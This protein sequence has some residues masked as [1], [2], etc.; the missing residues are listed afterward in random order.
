MKALTKSVPLTCES[1][2]LMFRVVNIKCK[3]FTNNEYTMSTI[4]C[5]LILE[6]GNSNLNSVVG[7]TDPFTYVALF[8]ITSH[9]EP[10][11]QPPLF[12]FSP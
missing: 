12:K 7:P 2:D 6:K 4:F 9:K 8:L 3:F 10:V 1:P 5:E 11:K